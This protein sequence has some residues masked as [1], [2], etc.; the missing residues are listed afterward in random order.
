M[1]VAKMVF[2]K[3]FFISGQAQIGG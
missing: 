2:V 3:F 1:I